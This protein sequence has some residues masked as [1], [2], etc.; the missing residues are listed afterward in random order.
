[1]KNTH[2]PGEG[3][4]NQVIEGIQILDPS[5]RERERYGPDYVSRFIPG[6][7]GKAGAGGPGDKLLA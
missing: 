4:K 7:A 3:N 5:F 6:S 1:M 2:N